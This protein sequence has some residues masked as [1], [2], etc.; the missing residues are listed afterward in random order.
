MIDTIKINFLIGNEKKT[1]TTPT[2][3]TLLQAA[4]ANNIPIVGHC[5][6]L[7][8]CG[9]CRIELE[10]KDYDKIQGPSEDE[11]D[12][13]ERGNNITNTS[14]LSCQIKLTKEMD[15]INIIIK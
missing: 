14:R 7:G 3:I 8:V 10:K 1:I 6:G 9:T 4:E 13:L 11:E 12:T 2:G 5:G 15:N